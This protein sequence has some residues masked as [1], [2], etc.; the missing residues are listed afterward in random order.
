MPDSI[1][2]LWRRQCL[3]SSRRG[4]VQAQIRCQATEGHL[5]WRRPHRA[6]ACGQRHPHSPFVFQV[7]SRYRPL[8]QPPLLNNLKR[9]PDSRLSLCCW[10]R[11][12][13]FSLSSSLFPLF[14]K[15]FEFL[16][17]LFLAYTQSLAGL[18]IA[19][20]LHLFAT[21]VLAALQHLFDEGGL[22]RP[23]YSFQTL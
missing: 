23:R 2:A 1:A 3:Y 19:S 11:F 10:L 9:D 4:Q 20:S 21:L 12:P 5:S 17:S 15:V 16:R 8:S 6:T 18:P 14:F 22:I 13:T 7:V